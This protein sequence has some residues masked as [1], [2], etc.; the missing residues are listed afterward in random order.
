MI[1]EENY[2]SMECRTKRRYV[3]PEWKVLNIFVEDDVLKN[4]T[5]KWE[6]EDLF[7]DE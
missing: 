3:I 4:S 5:E 1:R 7:G 6:E 2:L